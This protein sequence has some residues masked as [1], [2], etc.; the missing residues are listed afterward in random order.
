MDDH[1]S[2]RTQ[3]IRKQQQPTALDGHMTQLILIRLWSNSCCSSPIRS[4]VT[5]EA[6]CR[7][8]EVSGL[9]SWDIYILKHISVPSCPPPQTPFRLV[10]TRIKIH[11]PTLQRDWHFKHVRNII[12][13]KLITAI[14][15]DYWSTKISERS[16]DGFTSA[17][18]HALCLYLLYEE[19]LRGRR[20]ESCEH[21]LEV[22]I[23]QLEDVS[24]V[25][26]NTR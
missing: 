21:K 2:R 17:S 14:D 15:R 4:S 18:Q 24:I 9:I 10:G 12:K 1:D 11:P 26:V 5:T 6:P 19:T 20:P 23:Y 3:S 22:R 8:E 13:L 7:A 16:T 25:S